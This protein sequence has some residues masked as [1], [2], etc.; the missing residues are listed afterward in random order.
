M[1]ILASMSMSATFGH[2]VRV[3]VCG[4]CYR[5]ESLL[6]VRH[7]L[8]GRTLWAPPGGGVEP[9]ESLRTALVREFREETG[10]QIVPGEFLF[11]SEFID[12]PLHAIELFFSIASYRGHPAL[13]SDP[14][15]EEQLLRELDFFDSQALQRLPPAERH[16]VL[17]NCNNPTELLQI[18]GEFKPANR[19]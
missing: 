17:Q 10:L 6:L 12:P 8:E 4:L 14:E 18:R 15:I 13:G 1:A 11:F 5:Q 3:R 2:R 7:H 9:G 16:A 19:L